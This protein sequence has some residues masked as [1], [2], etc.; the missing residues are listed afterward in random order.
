MSN[1]NK[2]IYTARNIALSVGISALYLL[3]CY[4]LIGYKTEQLIL[5]LLVN[6]LLFI[7]RGTRK[8]ILAFLIFVVFWTLFDFM[9]AF[10]NYKFAKVHIEDIYLLEKSWFGVNADGTRLTLNEYFAQHHCTVLDFLAGCFYLCW[11]PVP[12]LFGI[13]LFYTKK[14]AGYIHFALT[15]LWVNLIGFVIYYLVPSAPPWYVELYG[16]AFNPHTPGN[17]AGLE[18]FDAL[19]HVNIFHAL[20]A[21]SSN[22]FA[23]MPSLHASYQVVTL[24]HAFRNKQRLYAKIFFAVVMLGIWFTAV[25]ASHHYLLDVVAGVLCAI[26]GI[27]SYNLMYKK[28]PSFRRVV[29]RYIQV[30][31]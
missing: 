29:D 13:Y 3:S 2:S 16:F 25:Y 12:I 19:L 7:T 1:S 6:A 11:V 4:W 23:A 24:Y 9:K 15:F 17:T 8:F 18:R 26:V 31:D 5:V 21:Q 27:I 20:Y 28:L 10:P 30:V 14:R 22:V